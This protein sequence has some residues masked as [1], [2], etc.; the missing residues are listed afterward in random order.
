[1]YRDSFLA[2]TVFI[3]VESAL[4]RIYD[5]WWS[6]F[7]CDASL[8]YFQGL[9]YLFVNFILFLAESPTRETAATIL[10]IFHRR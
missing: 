10:L 8:L 9:L 2:A 7:L 5:F 4:Y 6:E 3:L 1:M